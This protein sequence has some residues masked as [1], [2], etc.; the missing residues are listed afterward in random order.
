MEFKLKTN[1]NTYET[2]KQ[3]TR[4]NSGTDKNTFNKMRVRNEWKINLIRVLH[5]SLP[6]RLR[7]AT[8]SVATSIDF[9][10]DLRYTWR[11]FQHLGLFRYLNKKKGL[12]PSFVSNSPQTDLVK[13]T[14][15]CLLNNDFSELSHTDTS[16]AMKSIKEF[17]FLR[18]NGSNLH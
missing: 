17:F 5:E 18:I 14:P 13:C 8:T 6:D 10:S 15:R 11:H 7:S 2:G 16:C 3:Y 9:L 4:N 12:R 1:G